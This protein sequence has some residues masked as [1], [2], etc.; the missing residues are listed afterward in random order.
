VYRYLLPRDVFPE[1][2]RWQREVQEVFD[3]SPSIRGLGRGSFAAL[4]RD[5]L[6]H[7]GIRRQALAQPRRI[8]A[9]V[10]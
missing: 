2:D 9:N 1:L 10:S 3:L 8:T 7:I 4:N 6:L 5:G